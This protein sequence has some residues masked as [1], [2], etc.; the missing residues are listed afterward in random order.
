MTRSPDH[1]DPADRRTK[2]RSDAVAQS[3]LDA[4]AAPLAGDPLAALARSAPPP[5]RV[6]PALMARLLAVPHEVVQRL[7]LLARWRAAAPDLAP[8]LR[9]QPLAAQGG[10]L[11]LALVLGVVFGLLQTPAGSAD[12]V[13]MSGYVLGPADTLDAPDMAP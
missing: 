5:P 6:S 9:P 1:R 8:L 11:G 13:D 12:L 2:P 10:A 3:P 7:P 4:E